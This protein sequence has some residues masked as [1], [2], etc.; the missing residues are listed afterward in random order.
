[1]RYS[2]DFHLTRLLEQTATGE[3]FV[4]LSNKPTTPHGLVNPLPS[5]HRSHVSGQLCNT[6]GHFLY[7]F[8]E[9]LQGRE[10]IKNT[11]SMNDNAKKWVAALRS[12]EFKQGSRFLCRDNRYCCLGVAC[13]IAQRSGVSVSRKDTPSGYSVF[14]DGHTAGL[15]EEVKSWLGLKDSS[16]KYG[17]RALVWDNDDGHTFPKLA[18]IIESEPEGLFVK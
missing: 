8:V 6:D 4:P 11:L 13:V 17:H 9:R 5:R 18:D 10:Q 16:G 2:R 7:R 15:P 3:N 1:M 12:G 14:G